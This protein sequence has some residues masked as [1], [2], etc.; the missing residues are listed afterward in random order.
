MP[1]ADPRVS[2]DLV[3]R[4]LLAPKLK[5]VALAAVL[6]GVVVGVVVGFFAP[7]WLAL[8]IGVVIGVPTAASALLALRRRIWLQETRIESIGGL[9]TRRVDARK[10]LGVEL[11]VR[12]GRISEVSARLNDG[13]AEV[14]IPLAL[15]SDNGGRE[16]GVLGLR[17]L[18]DALSASELAA[19]AGVTSVLIEQLRA[20][21]RGAR[22]EDRPLYRAVVLARGAGRVPQTTLTD[23]D[24][25]SLIE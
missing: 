10:A 3:P 9:R 11:A 2:L 8:A 7:V 18:A 4:E 14:S 5:R 20:E 22:L 15:Y 13:S 25:A 24:V 12:C 21:A 1:A 16:L 6:V 19:A 23:H 17:R